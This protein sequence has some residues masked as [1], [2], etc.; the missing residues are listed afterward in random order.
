MNK[1]RFNNLLFKMSTPYVSIVLVIFAVLVPVTIHFI[2]AAIDKQMNSHL[3]DI[4]TLAHNYIKEEVHELQSN[5]ELLTDLRHVESALRMK[6]SAALTRLLLPAK[7]SLDVNFIAA[8]DHKRNALVTFIDRDILREDVM[9]IE[10]ID[11]G[12]LGVNLSSLA[13]IKD[14]IYAISIVSSSTRKE[15]N[16][17]IAGKAIDRPFLSAVRGIKY[18]ESKYDIFL[19]NL[20]GKVIEGSG[21]EMDIHQG[22]PHDILTVLMS[23]KEQMIQKLFRHDEHEKKTDAMIFAPLSFNNRISAIIGVHVPITNI[24]LAKNKIIFMIVSLMVISIILIIITGYMISKWVSKRI[25][26][27]LEGTREIAD[28]NLG[29]QLSGTGADELGAVTQSFNKMSTSLLESRDWWKQTFDSMH[30]SVS[31]H[32]TNGNIIMANTALSELVGQPVEQLIGRKCYEVFHKTHNHID[33]CP[34]RTTVKSGDPVYV[35][36]FEPKLDCWLSIITSP[37]NENGTVDRIVHIVRDISDRKKSE[38][39]VNHQMDRL[40]VLHSIERAVNSTV[41]L[42]S[43]LEHL[44]EQVTTRMGIDAAAVLLYNQQTK[45]L[46][47]EAGLGFRTSSLKRTRLHAGQSNAGRAAMEKKIVTIPDLRKDMGEFKRSDQFISEK[48]ITYFAVPL[49]AKNKVKGVMELFLRTQYYAK[50]EWLDFMETIANQAANAI[51]NATLFDN[52]QQSRNQLV[53]AYES[54]LEGWSLAMDMRDK[55]TEG[56][57]RRV[58]DLTLRIAGQSGISD[59]ELVHIKRGALLHDIGKIGIPDSILL[60]QDKLNE[61]EWEIMKLH[62]VYARE[63]LEKIEYLKPA[64]SIP[65]YHHEKWDGTGYPEKLEGEDIPLPARIFAIVDVW[66]ALRSDRPYRPAWPKDKVI[67]H[68]LSLAG[69]H[70]DPNLVEVFMKAI[71]HEQEPS[72]SG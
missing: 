6:D 44:T 57:S 43:T 39:V 2:T 63:M 46:E 67:D 51:D 22:V 49:I 4:S 60:K 40:N 29:F 23:K 19:Y 32:S 55:E 25:N 59:E 11:N 69:S 68:I 18:S 31:I 24:L 41:G 61:E 30:D 56:H 28:G 35:E 33:D 17:I 48:F 50:S 34:M 8:I 58:T 36:I 71:E 27:L 37:I 45:M 9:N 21:G 64:I 13:F 70:F 38:I 1:S 65:Y 52:L 26:K 42:R 20:D 12:L 66:D 7:L 3:S 53:L 72:I 62:P 5:L 47:F 10:L 15:P 16:I 14:K 54:T